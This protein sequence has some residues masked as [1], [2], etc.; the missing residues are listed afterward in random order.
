SAGNIEG[1]VAALRDLLRSLEYNKEVFAD[2]YRRATRFRAQAHQFAV[3]AI[4]A[5]AG[6]EFGKSLECGSTGVLRPG[7]VGGVD[8]H[9]DVHA[10]VVLFVLKARESLFIGFA[11]YFNC[12]ATGRNVDSGKD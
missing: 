5:H 9:S 7:L 1:A 8:D 12:G 6:I 4:V 10:H 11:R 2:R 3:G